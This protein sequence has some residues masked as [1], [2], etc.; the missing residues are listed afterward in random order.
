MT[1]EILE[2]QKLRPDLIEELINCILILDPDFKIR[3]TGQRIY[4][5]FH[6]RSLNH[7][8]SFLENIPK[9]D[10]TFVKEKCNNIMSNWTTERF[11]LNSIGLTGFIIPMLF[12]ESKGIVVVDE[13]CFLK[14]KKLEH[15]LEERMKELR[16]LYTIGAKIGSEESIEDLLKEST[17]ALVRGVQYPEMTTSVIKLDGEKYTAKP[18]EENSVKNSLSCDI[19]VNGKM[20]GSVEVCYKEKMDFISEERDLLNEVSRMLAR[21][22]E[23]KE[24]E[25]EIEMQ[26]LQ[27]DKLASLGQLVSGIAHEINNPNTF[28]LGNIIIIEEALKDILP[29]LD[30]YYEKKPELKIARLKYNIFKEN[31]PVL[32]NDILKGA[33]RIKSIV[34]DLRKFARRD[35]GLLNDDID[36]NLVVESCLRLVRNQ[37]KRNSEIKLE[38]ALDIPLFKGNMQKLEQVIVN[39]LINASQAIE[40]E[41]GTITILTGYEESKKEIRLEIKD[42]GKGMDENTVKQIFNPFFTT[43]RTRGGT[44]LGLSIAYGIIKEHRGRID[45]DSEVNKGTAFII[46]LPVN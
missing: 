37:I 23:R 14:A 28:I 35:E 46:H 26:L 4:K 27:A 38:E 1:E 18:P 25:K 29:I 30:K 3:V 33:N 21:A 44:G 42:N 20:R 17:K 6:N 19:E 24:L 36:I 10:V 22:I 11:S 12:G 13:K 32:V 8:E 16:C 9:K 45:V 41:R 15:D 34:S 40:K 39:M 31:I 2:K 7:G 43:K 5:K